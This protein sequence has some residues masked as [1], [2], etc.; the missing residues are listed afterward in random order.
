M[1]GDGF[2]QVVL[3]NGQECPYDPERELAQI[4]CDSCSALNEVQVFIE[5]GEVVFQGFV[6]EKC[7]AWNAPQS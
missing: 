6:C 5:N 7:N 2:T 3:I 4:Y 1:S